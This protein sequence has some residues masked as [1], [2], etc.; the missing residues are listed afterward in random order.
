MYFFVGEA[1]KIAVL[2]SFCVPPLSLCSSNYLQLKIQERCSV[3]CCFGFCAFGFEAI[4]DQSC[5]LTSI[6]DK[7]YHEPVNAPF[8]C[9]TSVAFLATPEVF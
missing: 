6:V 4:P 8:F 5:Y 3:K 9:A 2:V 7:T 1:L